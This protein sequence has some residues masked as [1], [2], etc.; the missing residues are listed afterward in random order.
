MIPSI[1][2]IP[3]RSDVS[4]VRVLARNQFT[5]TTA[6]E[7]HYSSTCIRNTRIKCSGITPHLVFAFGTT[8]CD[9]DPA[10]CQLELHFTAVG[11]GALQLA[12]LCVVYG[13]GNF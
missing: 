10:C 11:S 6:D 3:V 8:L 2:V 7:G 12:A 5:V 13:R 1:P 4:Y 9:P